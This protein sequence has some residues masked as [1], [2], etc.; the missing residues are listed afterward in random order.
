[1][2]E[3]LAIAVRLGDGPVR[4]YARYGPMLICSMLG[5]DTLEAI[6]RKKPEMIEDIL[7]FG[8]NYAGN[9]SHWIIAM[10]YMFRL[11]GGAR[12]RRGSSRR[13]KS[14][15]IDHPPHQALRSG[16]G[17]RP[18]SS[19]GGNLSEHGVTM[20]RINAEIGE[21]RAAQGAMNSSTTTI[22]SRHG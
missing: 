3:P 8:D 10:D 7:H 12:R 9:W 6:D 22:A 2:A 18:C 21:G 13:E 4:A 5:M 15:T 17:R 19:G 14:T 1:M 11:K 16:N 20:V